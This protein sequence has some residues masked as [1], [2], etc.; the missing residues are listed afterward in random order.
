MKHMFNRTIKYHIVAFL[1]SILTFL[2]LSINIGLG[3]LSFI[4][5]FFF[6]KKNNYLFFSYFIQVV[7]FQNT[8]IGWFANFFPSPEAFKIVHGLNILMPIL[9]FITYLVKE[10]INIKKP[11]FLNLSLTLF[12]LLFIYFIFGLYNFGFQNSAAYLRLLSAPILMLFA[13]LYFSTRLDPAFFNNSLKLMLILCAF[14]AGLQILFPKEI[15]VIL[16]ELSYYKLKKGIDTWTELLASYGKHKLFNISWIN[17][18]AIRVGS[19][20]K[21]VISLGYFLIILGI[22]IYWPKKRLIL[23]LIFLLVV[24]AVNS[25]G[26]ILMFLC[27]LILYFLIEKTNLSK[28]LSIGFYLFIITIIAVIGYNN[29]NEHLIG[30]VSGSKYLSTLGNGLGFSGN[31]SNILKTSWDGVSLPDLGYWTRFQNGSESVFGVLFSSMGLFGLVYVCYFLVIIYFINRIND[32]TNN[33]W[34]ILKILSIVLFIQGIF[35]EEAFSPYA[36]GLVM[37]LIGFNINEIQNKPLNYW[38]SEKDI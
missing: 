34:K 15:G 21:S 28:G 27:V 6:L 7:F 37:F 11:N 4:I 17:I 20:I 22:Y 24:L 32:E 35:Q 3:F 33:K 30:F 19:L 2:I 8:F 10:K 18:S 5:I 9:L 36:F 29:N 25:K 23:F 38:H 31:L 12:L 14:V 1:F 26:V 13:G 16:N